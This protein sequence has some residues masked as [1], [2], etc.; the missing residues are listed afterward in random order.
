MDLI[1]SKLE[2]AIIT[3][4]VSDNKISFTNERGNKFVKMISK[5]QHQKLLLDH[6]L[7][8]VQNQIQ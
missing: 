2:E 3:K 1:L 5:Y 6:D 4:D 8:Y 7:E